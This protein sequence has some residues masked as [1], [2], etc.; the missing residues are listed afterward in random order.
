M[1]Q[2]ILIKTGILLPKIQYT[3][4]LIYLAYQECFSEQKECILGTR[5][6]VY[7]MRLS[8]EVLANQIEHSFTPQA[9]LSL[10]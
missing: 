1:P 3:E 7:N 8:V 9:D 6:R 10:Q 4:L 2:V 5:T